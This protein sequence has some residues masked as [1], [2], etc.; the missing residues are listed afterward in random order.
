M[1]RI[2]DT[3]VPQ[4]A[5][6]HR[7]YQ[8]LLRKA[9]QN[10]KGRLPALRDAAPSSANV[11]LNSEE[12]KMARACRDFESLFIQQMLTEMRRGLREN[13]VLGSQGGSLMAD[14]NRNDFF[15]DQMYQNIAGDMADQGGFGIGSVL[16]E[17]LY[18]QEHPEL[19]SAAAKSTG[20]V[21]VQDLRQNLLKYSQSVPQRQAWT[22]AQLESRFSR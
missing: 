13:S 11:R 2:D 20:T 10:E 1:T 4:A 19:G 18:R 16:F 14:R 15:R 3:Q 8:D 22:R 6:I 9:A 17:Q 12:M 21:E 5:D 7:K